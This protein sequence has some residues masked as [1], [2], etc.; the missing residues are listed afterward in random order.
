MTLDDLLKK[1][2]N[3]NVSISAIESRVSYITDESVI[4]SMK[5]N[6]DIIRLNLT[7]YQDFIKTNTSQD[8][9]TSA[10]DYYS[11]LPEPNEQILRITN[12]L[13]RIL[14]L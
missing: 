9:L 7:N 10:Y 12:Y 1:M 6:L 4:N 14:F 11:S 3:I 5:K 13:K 2:D 8:D